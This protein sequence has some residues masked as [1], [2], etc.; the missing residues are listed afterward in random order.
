MIVFEVSVA[1]I[2][3]AFVALVIYLILTL[4]GLTAF[5]GQTQKLV[6]KLD[7]ELPATNDKVQRLLENSNQLTFTVRDQLSNFDPLLG[8]IKILG[9]AAE[10][11]LSE[12]EKVSHAKK[13]NDWKQ[14]VGD[15]LDLAA[16]GAQVW[17]KIQ[18]KR[19]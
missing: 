2:A 11:F 10:N 8:S 4:K 7:N 9:T 14:N 5:L 19:S 12:S 15:I 1:I 13:T 17:Q 18:N 6:I 3:A 16:L